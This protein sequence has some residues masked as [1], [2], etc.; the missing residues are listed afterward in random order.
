MH[1]SFSF[2]VECVQNAPAWFAQRLRDAM[3]GA[4]TEDNTLVRI[5][6][7]RSEIDLG[8]IKAEY[9]NLFD[10]TLESDLKVCGDGTVFDIHWYVCLLY[11]FIAIYGNYFLL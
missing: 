5:I 2:L 7:T 6:T 1:L 4:G 11:L 8:R 10:K 3:Q 9:E